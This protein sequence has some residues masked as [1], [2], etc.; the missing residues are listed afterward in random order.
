MNGEI[1]LPL[2]KA[3]FFCCGLSIRPERKSSFGLVKTK[4][5]LEN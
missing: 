4:R 1:L 3:D 5:G 2:A